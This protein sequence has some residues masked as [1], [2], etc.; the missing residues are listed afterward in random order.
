M[1][2]QPIPFAIG[3]LVLLWGLFSFTMAATGGERAGLHE[4]AAG[5]AEWRTPRQLR[6]THQGRMRQEITFALAAVVVTALAAL[7]YLALPLM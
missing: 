4:V 1:L 7:I 3:A 2:D 5:P 6:R